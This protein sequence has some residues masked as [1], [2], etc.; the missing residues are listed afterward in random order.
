VNGL[1][2]YGPAQIALHWLSALLIVGTWTIAQ[3]IHDFPRD[4]RPAVLAIHLA[5]G[6]LF[7]LVLILRLVIRAASR[8]PAAEPGLMGR[9]ATLIH[10]AL[11]ALMAAA[12]VFGI[13]NAWVHGNAIF[14]FAA[15]L[16]AA[17][18]GRTIRWLFSNLHAA[19]ANGV[20]IVAGVH[21]A[22]ALFHHYILRD[23]VLRR[24]LPIG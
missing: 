14:G 12:V 16:P 1:D 9:L 18:T 2:R 11:Y 17:P 22:A 20:V 7:G 3:V 13:A 24:M 6:L 21:A 10:Q 4:L 23:G 5:A 19:A 8:A 15:Y